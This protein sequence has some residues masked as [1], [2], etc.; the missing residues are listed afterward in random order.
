MLPSHKAKAPKVPKVR[1][2]VS[3][4]VPLARK[5]EMR[6]MSYFCARRRGEAAR[7]G[8]TFSNMVK[9]KP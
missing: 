3:I 8:C 1:K 7:L 2:C 4:F 9:F 5:A 6:E